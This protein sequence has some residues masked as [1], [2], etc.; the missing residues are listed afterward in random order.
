MALKRRTTKTANLLRSRDDGRSQID[1]LLLG[2]A[3]LDVEMRCLSALRLGRQGGLESLA[4]LEQAASDAD[5]VVEFCARTALEQVRLRVSRDYASSAPGNLDDLHRKLESP[6]VQERSVAIRE[7]DLHR[8]KES[9][10]VLLACLSQ[11]TDP[12]VLAPLVRTILS[13]KDPAS[14][15]TMLHY[16]THRDPHVRASAVE[17]MWGW[18]D[19]AIL[20]TVLPL[21]KDPSNQVRGVVF[22]LIIRK[23]EPASR[24]LAERLLATKTLWMQLAAVYALGSLPDPWARQILIKHIRDVKVSRLIRTVAREA[25]ALS[26]DGGEVPLLSQEG[27]GA[28]VWTDLTRHLPELPEEESFLTALQSKDPLMRVHALQNVGRFPPT[29]SLDLLRRLVELEKDTLVLATLVKAL[30]KV[31]GIAEVSNIRQFLSHDD[32]RVRSNALEALALVKLGPELDEICKQVLLDEE[33]PRMQMQA[34]AHLFATDPDEA[35]RHFRG[36]ILGEDAT[37]RESALHIMATFHDDRLLD[38][39]KDALK[40]PRRGVYD[41]V[42]E[43]LR[44]MATSWDKARDLLDSYHRGEVAGEVLDGEPVSALLTAMNSQKSSERMRAMGKLVY[45]ND[46]RVNMVLELNLS[47][48]DSDVCK[49]AA[50][51][52]SERHR[53][54]TLPRL[55]L[56]LGETFRDM[57]AAGLAIVPQYLA[58][59]LPT[60][61]SEPGSTGQGDEDRLRWVGK[62]LY[63]A[64]EE[65]IDFDQE[66]RSVCLDI[67]T[68][69]EQMGSLPQ[70]VLPGESLR[71]TTALGLPTMGTGAQTAAS[72]LYRRPDG[73]TPSSGVGQYNRTDGAS[74]TPGSGGAYGSEDAATPTIDGARPRTPWFFIATTTLCLIGLGVWWSPWDRVSAG[75][76]PASSGT[77]DEGG[78]SLERSM[79]LLD[80]MS[81]ESQSDRFIQRFKGRQVIFQARL[82][83]V[84]NSSSAIVRSGSVLFRIKLP[85]PSRSL[86]QMKPPLVCEVLGSIGRNHSDGSIEI[87]GDLKPAAGP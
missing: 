65:D 23:G 24:T 63:D 56:R 72:G 39:L 62:V 6:Y 78:P 30:A 19:P 38:V 86:E 54:F 22:V 47:N 71:H 58:E 84:N 75:G 28:T 49:E 15:D 73:S 5:S 81:L 66:L 53:V 57:S 16:S 20:E 82:I 59:R 7:L 25:I 17:G 32:A 42:H 46:P 70:P 55:Y 83:Q 67:R 69:L 13:F 85:R 80:A 18:S 3:S 40:D 77:D 29:S 26:G 4:P 79:R 36:R 14:R 21:L 68:A 51:T 64:F 31:G 61:T 11:E 60:A 10:P 44:R 2:L 1:S 27:E 50:R 43:A 35:V 34:A 48:R 12:I 74:L 37:A 76:G 9:L 87:E 45:A 41:R 52:L 33:A 8:R